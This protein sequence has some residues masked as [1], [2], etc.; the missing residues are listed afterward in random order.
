[1]RYFGSRKKIFYVHFRNIRGTAGSF[2]ETFPDK[3]QVDMLEAMKA[4]TEVAFDGPICPDHSLHIA[5]DTEWGHRYWAYAV[6]YMK[7][8]QKVLDT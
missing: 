5:G 6:G 7:G 4:Y 3:G 1:I 8:L 2:V